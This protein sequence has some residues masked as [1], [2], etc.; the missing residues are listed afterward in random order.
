MQC[1]RCGSSNVNVQ[2][3]QQ[4]ATTKTKKTGCLLKL[5]RLFLILIT[6]GLWLVFGKK[7]EKSQT[8]FDNQKRAVCQKCGNSWIC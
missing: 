4:S 6:C 2:F 8:M 7:K 1:P 3:V 5:G